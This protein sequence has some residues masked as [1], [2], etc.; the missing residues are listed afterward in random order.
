MQHYFA[1]RGSVTTN[2]VD[3]LRCVVADGVYAARNP[4][5]YTPIFL[6][7]FA[8]NNSEITYTKL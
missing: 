4:L 5:F 1:K 3:S 6:A 2:I 8:Q 7:K